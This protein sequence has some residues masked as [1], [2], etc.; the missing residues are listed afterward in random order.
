MTEPLDIIFDARCFQNPHLRDRG[1]GRHALA[2]V[3]NARAIVGATYDVRLLALADSLQPPLPEDIAALFDET[4]QNAYTG[5]M[6]RPSWF[7][8]LSPMTNDP[9]FVVRLVNHPQLLTAA[10]VYDFIPEAEPERYLPGAAAKLDYSLS[11]FWLSQFDLFWPISQA[12]ARELQVRLQVP[13]ARMTVT[14]AS[15]NADFRPAS[16]DR[17]HPGTPEHVLAVGGADSR[18]NIEVLIRAHARSD[19]VR[20]RRIA[21]VV[22]GTYPEQQHDD[23]RLL[24]RSA[25]GAPE[26]LVLPGYVAPDELVKLYQHA[27]CV[28][29]PSRLEGFSLPVVEAMAAGAPVIASRI[30]VHEELVPSADLLFPPDDEIA[31]AAL[32]TRLASDAAFRAAVIA[33]QASVWPRFVERNVAESAW[34]SIIARAAVE[35][36]R[37]P[38]ALVSRTRRPRMAV[39]TPLPPDE[40][41]VAH[42]TAPFLMELGK[43]VDLHVFT[44]T[45]CAAPVPAAVSVRPHAAL[46]ALSSRFD[47]V[48][49]VM[50]NSRFH[51]GIFDVLTRYGGACIAHDVRMF[52]FYWNFVGEDRAR[53]LAE[54][55]LKRPLRQGEIEACLEDESKLETFYLGE[56]ADACAPLFFHSRRAVR[57]TRELCGRDSLYLPFA[58]Y[59]PW[60]R[61]QL[62]GRA[63]RDARAEMGIED[64]EIVLA[65]F[66][67]IHRTKS[68]RTIVLAAELLR[69]WK[70]PIKLYFVGSVID[71]FIDLNSFCRQSSAAPHIRIVDQFMDEERYRK[72]LLAADFGI[73]LRSYS[74]GQPSGCLQDCIAAGLPT[75]AN[76]NLC[77]AIEAP[78][79][80]RRVPDDASPLSIAEALA[81]MMETDGHTCRRHDE[82]ESYMKE[83]SFSVYTRRLLD[84]LDIA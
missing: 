46:P 73:Q 12:S 72:F 26:L 52:G 54:R 82:R 36:R 70:Y 43:H 67:L 66:G 75:V 3:R 9:L 30:P 76:D 64:D 13:E 69:S 49:G 11:K 27:C 56:L 53:R 7:V 40:S 84:A 23:L 60:S 50:G 8:E 1:I 34:R 22:T 83:H 62:G 79:Y 32:M 47:R 57:S 68:P 15:I 33:K 21:L 19:F 6:V 42:F 41:G 81:E 16:K 71:A 45:P 78:G 20:E 14:G 24:H 31:I 18:K 25:G 65:T 44:E 51:L 10:V 74:F 28:V 80:I 37:P 2:L 63:R 5:A 17:P 58:V 29:V 4:K 38:A 77:E 61:D 55:E 35:P 48:L 39:M 59:R